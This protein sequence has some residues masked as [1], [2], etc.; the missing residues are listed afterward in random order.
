MGHQQLVYDLE[1]RVLDLE[2][3]LSALEARLN[4]CQ[5]THD[6]L[7]ELAAPRIA[8]GEHPLRV[9]RELRLMTQKQV[10]E[11]C[12]LRP[13]QVSA[14]E[15]GRGYSVA[16]ARKLADALNVPPTILISGL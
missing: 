14:I 15:C 4:Q 3:K 9:I 7:T 8:K 12:G 10:A 2:D 1:L 16:T 6:P 5:S 13:N 11:R